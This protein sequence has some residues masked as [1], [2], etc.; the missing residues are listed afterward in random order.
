[1]T[2]GLLLDQLS[3]PKAIVTQELN[4][5]I[6]KM[7]LLFGNQLFGL[8]QRSKSTDKTETYINFFAPFESR[9]GKTK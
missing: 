2:P 9:K 4:G 3:K 7:T 5:G 6:D 1:L 8:I